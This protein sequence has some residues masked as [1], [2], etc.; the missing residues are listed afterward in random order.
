MKT[1]TMVVETDGD[2]NDGSL[3]YL[4]KRRKKN[5]S[6]VETVNDGGLHQR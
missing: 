6:M 3:N 5:R 4:N 1:R 2:E